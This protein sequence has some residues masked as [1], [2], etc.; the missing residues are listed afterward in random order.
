MEWNHADVVAVAKNSCTKCEGTG[1]RARKIGEAKTPC[2]CVLREMFRVCYARFRQCVLKAKDIRQ[3]RLTHSGASSAVRVWGRPTEEYIADFHLLAKRALGETSLEWSVFK[4]HILLGADWRLCCM[5]MK[6]DRGTF[7]HSVYR[8]Q[9]KCGNAFRETQ[10][11][12]LYPVDEYFGG[13]INR[14][15]VGATPVGAER[16]QHVKPPVRGKLTEMPLQPGVLTPLRGTGLLTA[17]AGGS[18]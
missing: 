9:Q 4:Y 15:A 1:M 17:T 13:R 11:F 10:P 8:M 18:I 3:V 7:F 16:F 12:A 5:K 2:N 14:K 6:I